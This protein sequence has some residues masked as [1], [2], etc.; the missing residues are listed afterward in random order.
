MKA[1]LLIYLMIGFFWSGI[2]VG[3]CLMWNSE[4]PKDSVRVYQVTVCFIINFLVWP[5]GMLVNCWKRAK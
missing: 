4:N 5:L 1:L 3:K 2:T